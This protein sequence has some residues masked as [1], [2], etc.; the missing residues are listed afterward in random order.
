MR[1]AEGEVF[2]AGR[3]KARNSEVGDAVRC[4]SGWGREERKPQS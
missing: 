1:R 2:S 3:R 4:D